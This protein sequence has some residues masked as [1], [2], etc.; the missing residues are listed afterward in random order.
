MDA[1]IFSSEPIKSDE[2]DF[3]TWR[4]GNYQVLRKIGTGGMGSVYL[5]ARAD[6]EFKKYVAIKVIR[7]GMDTEDIISRFRR[8]RQ[9]LASL[10]HPNIARFLDGGTTQDYLP[11][12]VMEYVQGTPVTEYSNHHQLN[13]HERLNLYRS[14]CSAVQYAHQNLVVHRDLKPANIL[15]TDDGTVKL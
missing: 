13:T 2:K 15:V 7:K 9:M 11:Y 1:E 5:G 10:D 8:E 6:Q 12:F 3:Q 4:L 14:V